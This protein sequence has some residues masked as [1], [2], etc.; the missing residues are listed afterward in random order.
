[1]LRRLVGTVSF[2]VARTAYF[3]LIHSVMDYGIIAWGGTPPSNY[4]FGLQRKCVRILARLSYREDCRLAFKSLNI[5]TLPSMFILRCLL[6]IHKNN[7]LYKTHADVHDYFT[8]NCMNFR[9]DYC[10]LSR[11]QKSYYYIGKLLHNVTPFC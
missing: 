4:V 11:T 7:E 8:R 9:V 1:M 10:R 5:L 3:A 2:E 6:Y